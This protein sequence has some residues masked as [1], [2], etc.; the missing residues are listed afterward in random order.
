MGEDYKKKKKKKNGPEIYPYTYMDSF[1]NILKKVEL[2]ISYF[3]EIW[4]ALF[5]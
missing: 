5:S 2:K 4:R 3:L 1:G